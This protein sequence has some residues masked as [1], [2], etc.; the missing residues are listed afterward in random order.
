[1]T[2]AGV[3]KAASNRIRVFFRRGSSM[4]LTFSECFRRNV[5]NMVR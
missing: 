2:M 1:M 4:I 5:L 3:S